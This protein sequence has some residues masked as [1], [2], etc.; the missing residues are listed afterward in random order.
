MSTA[1][2]LRLLTFE[3]GRESFVID[4]MRLRQIVPYTGSTHVPGAP[5]FVEGI[6]VVRNRAI[7]IIDLRARFFPSDT[8]ASPYPL[9]L[10]TSSRVGTLGLKVDGVRRILTVST[11]EILP[12]PQLVHD[13]RGELFVG[14]IREGD[15]VLL[16]LDLD[17]FLS[18]EEEQLHAA[19]DYQI[20]TAGVQ[21]A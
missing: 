8:T 20:D 1:R 13:L 4:I 10:V 19:T 15:S 7:P 17:N 6:T 9:I 16:L 14:I 11:E 5:P 2:S 18:K 3:V 21:Q 12:A